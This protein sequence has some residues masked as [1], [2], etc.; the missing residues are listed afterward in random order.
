M[1]AA[2][3]GGTVSAMTGGKF[4]NGA[5]TA[6][7]SRAFNDEQNDHAQG[8][9]DQGLPY[10][11][12][13]DE[14]FINPID[15]WSGYQNGILL[16]ETGDLPPGHLTIL[17]HGG[18]GGFMFDYRGVEL[19]GINNKPHWDGERFSRFV[20]NR[21][22]QL[23]RGQ[24]VVVASC[25]TGSSEHPGFTTNFSQY[26]AN[27]LGVNVISPTGRLT[28]YNGRVYSITNSDGSPGTWKTFSPR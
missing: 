5:V 10:D 7:F 11:S 8:P 1:A 16:S 15:D 3:L 19:P 24:T 22:P 2:A 23:R 27:K 21:Y 26:V 20:R 17:A 4:A 28:I 18:G 13:I 14:I 25:Y 9:A 6:A 12:I